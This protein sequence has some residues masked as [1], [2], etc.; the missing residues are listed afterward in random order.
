MNAKFYL[1]KDEEWLRGANNDMKKL[2][3][4]I[5]EKLNNFCQ[6]KIEEINEYIY[7]VELVKGFKND[8]GK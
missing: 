1:L 8:I 2:Y 3:V 7:Y 6:N 4:K 5:K